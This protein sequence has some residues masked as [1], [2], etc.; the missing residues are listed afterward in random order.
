MAEL[1]LRLSYKFELN[2]KNY[3]NK[4]K[5]KDDNNKNTELHPTLDYNN[6]T[7][8]ELHAEINSGLTKGQQAIQKIRA[9]KT[10]STY[11]N[12]MIDNME[13]MIRAYIALASKTFSSNYTT[14]EEIQVDLD[15]KI[16]QQKAQDKE[17]TS[18]TNQNK[19]K[20]GERDKDEIESNEEKD[21]DN[22]STEESEKDAGD[23]DNR[24]NKENTEDDSED[25]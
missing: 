6:K 19:R 2:D 17:K 3:A 18:H 12:M 1:K 22:E 8:E 13:N 7:N 9:K 25:D 16:A 4:D 10:R 24:S 15:S 14:L 20:E 5:D 11:D 21:S 23:E